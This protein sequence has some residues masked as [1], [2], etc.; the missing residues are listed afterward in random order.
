MLGH[1]V[2]QKHLL[3]YS[4]NQMTYELWCKLYRSKK[5]TKCQ[6]IVGLYLAGIIVQMC[7]LALSGMI[8]IMMLVRVCVE[9]IDSTKWRKNMRL[10]TFVRPASR[11]RRYAEEGNFPKHSVCFAKFLVV[12]I[13]QPTSLWK[14]HTLITDK[15]QLYWHA[16][17]FPAFS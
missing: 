3:Y 17:P 1:I 9:E 15:I 12:N 14:T 5:W 8:L 10:Q 13:W 11:P 7:P 2:A 4:I 16:L 6:K